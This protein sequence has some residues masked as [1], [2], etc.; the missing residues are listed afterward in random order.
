VL[1]AAARTAEARALHDP[2]DE[3][4]TEEGCGAKNDLARGRGGCGCEGEDAEEQ[5]EQQEVPAPSSNTAV[6]A[7]LRDRSSVM[8]MVA[9][10]ALLCLLLAGCAQALCSQSSH[11]SGSS[12]IQHWCRH[13]LEL[14]GHGHRAS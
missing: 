11:E 7:T 4:R 9:A 1:R 10:S 2:A 6:A 14:D 5:Q 8:A 3:H 12:W 13:P